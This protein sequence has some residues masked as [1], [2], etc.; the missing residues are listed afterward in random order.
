VQNS[1]DDSAPAPAASAE[2][3]AHTADTAEIATPEIWGTVPMRNKN[4]TGRKELLAHLYDDLATSGLAA[5]V[6]RAMH[7][8][9]G[10]GKTQI[11]I[12][13]AYRYQAS[14][15]VVWWI[16]ADQDSLIESSIAALAPRLT[17]PATGAGVEESAAAV[18]DALRVGKP[19]HR[20][21]LIFDAAAGPDS[22]RRFR[23][24]GPGHVLITSRNPNWEEVAETVQVDVFNRGESS[25]FLGRRVP[26]IDKKD[27]D[28]LA[29]ALGDLPLA[30]D[31][32][33]GLQLVSGMPVS[34]YLTLLEKRASDVLGLATAGNYPVP[35]TA[36][37]TASATQLKQSIPE[38][39]ELLRACAFFGPQPIPRDVLRD[40]PEVVTETLGLVLREPIQFSKAIGS[41]NS[42]SLVRVEPPR[43]AIV[44]HRLVQAL[45]RD[46][47]PADDRDRY[48]H[49]VHRLLAAATPQDPDDTL[50]WPR[51]VDLLPHYGPAGIIECQDDAVRESIL[52]V[53]RYHYMAG[54]FK[55]ALDLA[56]SA[57][58]VWSQDPEA[59]PSALL[60]AKRHRGAVLRALGKYHDAF[61]VN[62]ATMAEAI[63]Q[64]G[65]EHPET[66]RITNSHGA[67]IRAAGDFRLAYKLDEDSVARH[68]EA[69]GERDPM[70]LRAENNF[71]LDQ[72]LMG[73]FRTACELDDKVYQIGR[74]VYGSE[75]H[76]SV[77][78]SLNN[79]SRA[80][81]L[82]G[83]YTDACFMAEDTYAACCNHLGPVHP[84]TLRAARDLVISERL[85]KGATDEIV[86]HAKN[87]LAQ[88]KKRHGD[89]H[90]TTLAA[91]TALA[92]AWRD[93]GNLSEAIPL[94]EENMNLAPAVYAPDHPYWYSLRGN[95]AL[96]LRISGDALRAREIH[97]TS[98]A[99]LKVLLGDDHPYTLTC[100]MGLA[101]DLAAAGDVSAA[102]SVG[103]DTMERLGRVLWL[104]HPMS[105]ECSINL[106][107]DLRADGHEAEADQLRSDAIERYAR[108][109]GSHHPRVKAALDGQRLDFDFDP[110]P[111]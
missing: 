27:S 45:T 82:C 86:E 40:H 92:N 5:V 59:P 107:L 44:V 2:P 47:L 106:A 46:D 66:L 34:E 51:F 103:Q 49:D 69:F 24:N 13:Y 98:I 21:L 61:D 77:L 23:F 50:K 94:A 80:V 95:L 42:Y 68:L 52:C 43:G 108:A 29:D 32:A 96:A 109:L 74:E 72:A 37:W 48:R 79:L 9:A 28:S 22:V 63:E 89:S 25:E 15:D 110:L 81:R 6:P 12:E 26:G 97:E 104:D 55:A 78:S 19:Y 83:K 7:G 16:P 111:F 31:Q 41:L 10:V 14:Y 99:R 105:L 100:A 62:A 65:T 54:G 101:S 11:A 84:I 88:H 20:W 35:V 4:F 57:L 67:D 85:A 8:L 58:T 56:D 64:L 1:P 93:A 76:P 30:L 73:E 60:A 87:I 3:P 18:L 102:R 70:T 91:A 36:T 75:S 39:I 71:A 38:A 33:G 90:P 17:L 53:M